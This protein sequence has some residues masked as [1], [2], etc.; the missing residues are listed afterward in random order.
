MSMHTHTRTRI[1]LCAYTN[2]SVL[3]HHALFRAYFIKVCLFYLN[4]VQMTPLSDLNPILHFSHIKTFLNIVL[5]LYFLDT[6]TERKRSKRNAKQ[7]W[8]N[9][10]RLR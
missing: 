6:Q 5:T 7:S 3:W 2:I 10:K 1:N 8:K 9:A 4:Q